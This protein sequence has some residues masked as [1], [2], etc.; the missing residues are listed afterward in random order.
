MNS[1]LPSAPLRRMRFADRRESGPDACLPRDFTRLEN[2]RRI[3]SAIGRANQSLLRVTQLLAQSLAYPAA[4]IM[5]VGES[6]ARPIC[7]WGLSEAEALGISSLSFWN[8]S[9]VRNRV[10]IASDLLADVQH[11]Q[12]AH[13]HAWRSYA[14]AP[15]RAPNGIPVG[16]IAVL[17]RQPRQPVPQAESLLQ[18]FRDTAEELIRLRRDLLHEPVTD[19]WAQ[20]YLEGLLRDEWAVTYTHLR[21]VTVM[22]IRLS[23]IDDF[24]R[25]RDIAAVLAETFRRSSDIIGSY[26]EREFVAL[27]PETNAEAAST[28]GAVLCNRL[29]SLLQDASGRISI[30]AAVACSDA[31]FAAGPDRLLD[32]AEKAL[33]EARLGD[34]S[35]IVVADA[36]VGG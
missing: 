17:D 26:A 1:P 33:Q 9:V 34:A 11:S 2:G 10:L 23:S 27:L 20:H 5:M 14:V 22:R 32:S 12:R 25:L 19:A 15:L 36:A 24:N 28:L 16:G 6:A 18:G 35:R 29:G 8:Q 7:A 13:H 21:P 4:A 30:G 3:A 31:D